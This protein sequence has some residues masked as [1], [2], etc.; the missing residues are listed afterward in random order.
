MAII[1]AMAAGKPIVATRVGGI[2]DLVDEGENGFLVEAGDAL[3]MARSLNRLLADAELRLLMG[4]RARQHASARFR[5]RE[6]AREYRKVYYLVAGLA[7]PG[8]WDTL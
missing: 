3:D 6:V 5:L 2:P 1:E 7:T 4:A 8:R